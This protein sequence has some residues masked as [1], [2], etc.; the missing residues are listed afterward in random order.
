M[1]LASDSLSLL[2]QHKEDEEASKGPHMYWLGCS[3]LVSHS[4]PHFSVE[5]AYLISIMGTAVLG[6][7][8]KMYLLGKFIIWCKLH[9]AASAMGSVSH[10]ERKK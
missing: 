2:R 3:Q 1:V 9:H 8:S 7:H 4:C 10:R 6:L 5:S